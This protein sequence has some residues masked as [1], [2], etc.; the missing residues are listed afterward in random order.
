MSQPLAKKVFSSHP[1]ALLPYPDLVAVQFDSFRWFQETGLRELLEEISPIRDHAGRE[2]ELHFK[3]CIFDEPKSSAEVAKDRSLTYEAPLRM[4]V[5]LVNLVTGKRM[6]QEL[7]FGDFPIMTRKGT[8]I[9]SGVERVV[10]SQLVRSP[11]VYFTANYMRG[12]KFFGAKIIPNRGAWIEIESE[13]GGFVGMKIDRRRKVPVTAFLRTMG[14]ETNEAM[15]GAFSHPLARKLIE[16]TLK[17]DPAASPS[18]SYLEI[19][20]RLRPG[21]LV[22]P[23]GAQSLIDGMFKRA[24]RYDLSEV[25]RYKANQTLGTSDETSRLVTLRDLIRIIEEIAIR[26]ADP[27]AEANDIDHLGNRRLRAVGE[28]L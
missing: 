8:F 3:K 12:E 9:M 16:A 22:T 6:T 21:D 4:E 26:N 27:R 20:R 1:G 7:Y 11:G 25:G 2:F 5:E 28:L 19:Y 23:Q 24:D 14:L 15:L 10:I 13:P 18:E 17:S